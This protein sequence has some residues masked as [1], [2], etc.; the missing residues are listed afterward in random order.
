[1]PLKSRIC[2]RAAFTSRSKNSYIRSR[3][4]VTMHP[5]GIPSRSLNPAIDFFACV[6]TGLCPVIVAISFTTA[7]RSFASWVASPSP[8]LRIIFSSRGTCIRFV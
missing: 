8:T 4:S 7:S 1:M 6:T 5:T 2:G 3:R